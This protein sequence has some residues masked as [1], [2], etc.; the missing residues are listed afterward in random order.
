MCLQ[1]NLKEQGQLIRQDEFTVF[2]GR[3]KCQRRVFLFEELVLFSKARRMEGGL[4]VF[5]Y[6]LS[7]KVN[8][9][10]RTPPLFWSHSEV[11]SCPRVLQTADVGL[12]ESTGDTGLRFEIWFRRRTSKNQTFILQ[13]STADVKKT[14]T[15]DIARILWTQA[16][17]NKGTETP[18]GSPQRGRVLPEGACPHISTHLW[19]QKPV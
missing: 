3:R 14:W 2:T 5:I 19:F 4:D 12:T 13:A 7:F 18:G 9:E 6:K 10:T 8:Q 15:S 11:S 17:R 1:V 16:T